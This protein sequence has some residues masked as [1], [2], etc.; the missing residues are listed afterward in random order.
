VRSLSET[1][2]QTL[3]KIAFCLLVLMWFASD[4]AS[5]QYRFTQWTVDSGLPHS[6]VRGIVQ[7]PDGYLW[8]ATLNG[9]ARFDGVRFKVYDKGTTP[10]ISSSRFLAMVPGVGEDLWM[11]SDDYN[12]VRMHDGSF[13]TLDRNHGVKPHEVSAITNDRGKV[14]VLS[15]R[16]VLLWDEQKQRFERADF[17]TA[18]LE[19]D[20][21]RWRGTG[22]WAHRGRQL[23][24]FNRG[25]LTTF[26]M[27]TALDFSEIR[28]VVMN[29]NG[30]GWIGTKDGRIASLGTEPHPLTHGRASFPLHGLSP[31][32][33]RVDVT[34]DRF[35]RSLHVPVGGTDVSM[36]LN[37]IT[38][39]NEDN[40]WVGTETQGLYR[41]QRQQITV[42]SEEQGLASNNTNPVFRS[43][44]GEIWAGSWPGG[45][46]EIRNGKV[47]QTFG[48][49]QGI[50]GSI[51]SLFEDKDGIL[52]I[53]THSG[54]RKLSK[55]KISEPN[56]LPADSGAPLVVHQAPDGSILFGTERGLTI[57]KGPNIRHL[58]STNGLASDD[59]RALITDQRGDLWVGG[60]GGLT[61]IHDGQFT[62]WTEKEGLPN[63]NIRS[64]FEDSSGSI[65]V[66]T[67]DGGI[68]WLR[69]GKWITFNKRRGLFDNGAFQILEDNRKRLWISS[70]HGIYRLDRDQLAAVADGREAMVASV[71]YGRADGMLSAQCNGGG[72]PS[73]IKDTN[74]SLWFPTQIGLAI[75]DPEKMLVVSQPP[76]VQID[77]FSIDR[78]DPIHANLATLK[79]GQTNLEIEYT[80]LSYTKPEQVTFSYKMDGVDETWQRVGLR[81]TAYYTHL[82]PGNYT[83]R[84]RA[85]NSDGVGSLNDAQLAV[86][87]VP[88][89]YRRWWFLGGCATL[90]LLSIAFAWRRRVR[91]LQQ[92]QIRQQIFSRQLIASQEGERRRIAAEL[93]D[94]LGQR[95]IIINNLALF[96][97]RT[98]GKVKTEEE[99]RETV[100]EI[101][102]EATA[103]IEET[104]A[105]SYALRPFQLDR[106][107]LTRAI[108]ALC[109]TVAH[110]SEIEIE[111][112][113]ADIDDAFPEDMRIN[114]YRIVQEALNNVVKHSGATNAEVKILRNPV[115]VSLTIRDN[116]RG[117]LEKPRTSI[118]GQGGFGMTGMRERITLLNGSFQVESSATT[119]TL[120]TIVLPSLQR[121]TK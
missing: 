70:N 57:S 39:D 37:V 28:G 40:L 79:P 96:L 7:T 9:L 118:P 89:F 105:I 30:D 87:I 21:L 97:L 31:E 119:G 66:G 48:T 100:E 65:W 32:D 112:D 26:V 3:S 25:Q 108:E 72:W 90:V 81:R 6:G 110:A 103:A 121:S 106:L 5:A 42:L 74:G 19:F 116:G 98:K 93:H 51:S 47:V 29:A 104:R 10:E 102:G 64:I 45:L 115:Q 53:A 114:L 69:D 86:V 20:A 43:K 23:I 46:S 55:G 111:R 60:N 34:P 12:V 27:P 1:L 113:L 67:Y 41:I 99:K 49:A 71:S 22:F 63:N 59:V 58:D 14:W 38:S 75:V 117:I 18:D 77:G 85:R 8:V 107:G 61:R 62:R 16:K 76:R 109:K 13:L 78:Q 56:I 11:L 94:S 33:W 95:L 68:G 84:V 52:W 4:P 35:E 50:P 54:I 83:F 2:S 92:A 91:Q 73:G 24:C 17:S 120:L 88:P 44:S 101:S 36:N 82:P 15:E 80:A